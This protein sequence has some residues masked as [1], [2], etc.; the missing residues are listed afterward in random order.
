MLFHLE[1]K[2]HV[3]SFRYAGYVTHGTGGNMLMENNTLQLLRFMDM[4]NLLVF[5]KCFGKVL[6]LE[7]WHKNQVCELEWM[8]SY[9]LWTLWQTFIMENDA[10]I[11]I[12][13]LKRSYQHCAICMNKSVINCTQEQNI[14][15]RLTRKC[16]HQWILLLNVDHILLSDWPLFLHN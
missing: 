10:E 9:Q 16:I 15:N 6:L 3:T 13:L 5:M 7:I 12:F 8:E 14:A 4:Y 1:G 2:G 11:H